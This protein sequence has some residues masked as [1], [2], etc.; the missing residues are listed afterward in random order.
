MSPFVIRINGEGE[1]PGRMAN[2][3][4]QG[5]HVPKNQLVGDFIRIVDGGANREPVLNCDAHV[6]TKKRLAFF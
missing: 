2:L 1:V 5:L 3:T 4:I 6:E